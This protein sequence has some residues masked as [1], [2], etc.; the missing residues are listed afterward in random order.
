MGGY[1]GNRLLVSMIGADGYNYFAIVDETGKAVSNPV[2]YDSISGNGIRE[3]RF[4]YV[5]GE[6]AVICDQNGNVVFTTDGNT[7][8]SYSNGVIII[9]DVRAYDVNGGLLFSDVCDEKASVV[10]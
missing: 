9:D 3:N 6:A 8:G 10:Q 4:A 7:V 1:C 5:D 2:R